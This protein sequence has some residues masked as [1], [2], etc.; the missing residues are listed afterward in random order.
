[1]SLS[2]LKSLCVSVVLAG[3][4]AGTLCAAPLTPP[5]GKPVIGGTVEWLASE[6]PFSAVIDGDLGGPSSFVGTPPDLSGGFFLLTLG[7]TL[8]DPEGSFSI[9]GVGDPA[10]AFLTGVLEDLGYDDTRVTLVFGNLGGQ[11]A[12]LFGKR[13]LISFFD[14]RSQ[15]SVQGDLSGTA[16]YSLASIAAIPL[17]AGGVLLL[18]GLGGLFLIGRR[19]V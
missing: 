12:G 1:M 14:I 13:V 16:S 11:G 17:P 10:D 18:C 3:L 6:V 7:G 9:D 15:P 2:F 8:D 5:T 19:R 4:G